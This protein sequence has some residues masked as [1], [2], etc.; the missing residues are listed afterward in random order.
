MCIHPPTTTSEHR[1]SCLAS[2]ERQVAAAQFTRLPRMGRIPVR[3]PRPEGCGLRLGSACTV[4]IFLKCLLNKQNNIN[5]YQYTN[6]LICICIY[7]H[8]HI[9]LHMHIAYI[10]I[11]V[12]YINTV[13]I[14]MYIYISTHRFFCDFGFKNIRADKTQAP[15][16][17]GST[18]LESL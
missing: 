18:N 10:Y 1:S 5:K 15:W 7:L 17:L 12:L 9:D 8:M 6:A 2:C 13:Y 11:Y 14:C 16:G 3:A 4:L